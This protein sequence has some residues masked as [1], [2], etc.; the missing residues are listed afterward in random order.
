Y[1]YFP[2]P[3]LMAFVPTEEWLAE[4][5]KRV[6]ELPL[7]R[8]QRF[9]REYKL[10]PADA[11]AFVDD[12]PLGDYFE[13]VASHT[14]N[15]KG[16]ANWVINN[17]RALM[18]QTGTTL[19]DL[20]FEPRAIAELVSLVDLGK[21]SSK[22]AQEVF[23]EMFATG[24]SP[25]A[26]VSRKGLGQVSDVSAIEAFCDQVIAANPGPVSDYKAG[27]AAALNFLKGQ[28]M[29]LSRGRANPVLVG[30]ILEE[31]LRS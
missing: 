6:V 30:Q 23:S 27:K 17:L 16:A 18:A 13:K 26:I 2:D 10:P 8:K 25:A 28:V 12:V 29:K 14:Q 19:K 22:T 15:P 9:M 31:K 24:E 7:A 11:Q 21:I 20:K 1:R 4:V 3:D 5:R